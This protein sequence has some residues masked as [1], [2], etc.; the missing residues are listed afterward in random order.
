[1]KTKT[2]KALIQELKYIAGNLANSEEHLLE[3]A[4]KAQSKEDKIKYLK[5]AHSARLVRTEVMKEML[6]GGKEIDL[7]DERK[8]TKFGELWCDI[9]HKL[10]SNIHFIESIE[11]LVSLGNFDKALELL[12]LWDLNEKQL[13]IAIAEIIRLAGG[14]DESA[15]ESNENA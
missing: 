14:E 6:F 15:G 13:D 9:K 10:I 11:K 5:L 12:E 2:E 7:S 4:R 8:R 3:T 1:M